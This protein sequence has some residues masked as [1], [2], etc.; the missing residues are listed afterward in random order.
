MENKETQAPELKQIKRHSIMTK[1]MQ[2]YKQRL[3]RSVCLTSILWS[4]MSITTCKWAVPVMYFVHY[5]DQHMHEYEENQS[6]RLLLIWW[7]I[8]FSFAYADINLLKD[9]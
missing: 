5:V 8:K 3:G 7:K 6:L 4:F 1:E 2:Q 9:W